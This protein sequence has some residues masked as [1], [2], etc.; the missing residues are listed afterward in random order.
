MAATAGHR[1]TLD[2]IGKCSN[3]TAVCLDSAATVTTVVV[4]YPTNVN[5]LWFLLVVIG[6]LGVMKWNPV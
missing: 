4:P 2:P 1:L 6:T 5:L 3:N